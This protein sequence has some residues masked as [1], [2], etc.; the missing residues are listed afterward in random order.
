MGH[1][2]R[3]NRHCFISK[4][5]VVMVWKGKFVQLPYRLVAGQNPGQA[6]VNIAM[7]LPPLDFHWETISAPIEREFDRIRAL[8]G[9]KDFY[10]RKLLRKHAQRLAMG[11]KGYRRARL[12]T[13][14]P[15]WLPSLPV[16]SR[17]S[18]TPS[19]QPLFPVRL[20]F[21]KPHRKLRMTY[22]YF[23]LSCGQK[24]RPPRFRLFDVYRKKNRER[25][26]ANALRKELLKKLSTFKLFKRAKQNALQAQLSFD[27]AGRAQ[28]PTKALLRGLKRAKILLRGLK[29]A[30]NNPRQL[31]KAHPSCSLQEIHYPLLR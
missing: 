24:L 19:G 26:D 23:Y 2:K 4:T 28:T 14:Y 21:D 10:R 22:R 5:H 17:P 13:L 30:K 8:K 7:M 25:F 27:Y 1:W 12:G 9:A 20:S 31:L 16:S 18:W 6:S 11:R 15:A 3:G 29:R